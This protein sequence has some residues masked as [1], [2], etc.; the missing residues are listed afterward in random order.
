[1]HSSN[2]YSFGENEKIQIS[3]YF[4]RKHYIK[5]DQP[6]DNTMCFCCVSTQMPFCV[7]TYIWGIIKESCVHLHSTV[8]LFLFKLDKI[9][10]FLHQRIHLYISFN[11][12]LYSSI[13][14]RSYLHFHS[15]QVFTSF[16]C[17]FSFD[18]LLVVY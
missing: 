7:T 3:R 14:F 15:P 17:N 4:K 1:M 8:G 5:S 11:G 9:W 13:V 18:P 16:P 2:P 6:Q 12:C 10:I